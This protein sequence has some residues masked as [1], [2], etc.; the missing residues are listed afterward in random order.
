M[1]VGSC[2]QDETKGTGSLIFKETNQP[3]NRSEKIITQRFKNKIFSNAFRLRT[4]DKPHTNFERLNKEVII[5][6][7]HDWLEIILVLFFALKLL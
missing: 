3:K 1:V 4:K 7:D 6:A 5:F 2:E